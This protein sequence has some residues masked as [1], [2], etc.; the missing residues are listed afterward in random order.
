MTTGPEQTAAAATGAVSPAPIGQRLRRIWPYFSQS[1]SAWAIAVGATVVASATEPLVPALLQPLLDKGFRKGGIDIWMVPVSLLLLFGVRGFAGFLAQIALAKVTN[2][3]LLEL[4]KAMFRKLMTA[5]LDLFSNQSAS[6]LA[7]TVVYEVQNGSSMLVNSL[8]GLA[9][10][11]LTLL[12]LSSYLLY[13]NWRLTLIVTLL[14]PAIAWVMRVLSSRLYKLT[15]ASQAATDSLA[16]VVEENVL[17]HRDVRL[18]AAQESQATRFAQL[19]DALRRLSMKSVVASAAMTPA[20]QML[21]A[22]ALS[23]V[24]SVALLQSST[25]TTSVGSFVAFVT[26]M[27][28]LVAPIKHL[29]EVASPITRGL[30][31]LERGLDLMEKTPDEPGGDFSKPRAEGKISFINAR[32]A[33]NDDGAPAVDAL[34]LT[35]TPGETVA[36]VGAS[37]AGKTTLVNLLPRFVEPT[38]G[39]IE[40]DGHELREWQ[41]DALRG[42]F[43]L[44][45]QHVVMLNDTVAANVALGMAMDR[46]KVL[47]CLKAANLERFVAELPR[48]V[49]T[50]VGHNATQLSGG[51]RQRLAIARALYKDA[52]VLILDEATSALDTESERAVQEALQRLMRN[53]TTL[54]IA[55]RLSTVQHASRIVVMDAGRIIETGTHAEL[56]E[57]DG[58]YSR[59]YKLGLYD[60]DLSQSPPVAQLS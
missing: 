52:P 29:S 27:L 45:S 58:P 39:S 51:Q 26:A 9:R 10:D 20:T 5:R 54:V 60:A 12:A 43:A 1:P 19:S 56:I 6:A 37:G 21:A 41:I 32:V 34:N 22:A 4:R 7:N 3:G 33:Y 35:I 31:A 30:A 40:L 15:K 23:A 18:H 8:M 24:I 28:M 25:D 55:H 17:A 44:V 49:D 16:Y 57:R 50:L 59:L 48:G 53:R 42:Q 46:D 36:L 47:V 11:T 2:I 13:L 14:I 38:S